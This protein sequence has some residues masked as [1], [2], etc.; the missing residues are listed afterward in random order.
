MNLKIA[1]KEED[2]K[3]ITDFFWKIWKEEFDLERFD[4]ID[5][6]KKWT[7]IFITEKWKI[8]SAIFFIKK[9]KI[10]KIWRFWTLKNFRWKGLWKKVFL[11]MEDF[12]KKKKVKKLQIFSEIKNISMYEKFWFKKIW[13]L[14]KVWN[15]KA[16]MM[17][18]EL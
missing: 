18:K 4:R 17:E 9:D 3:K 11:K 8:L 1:K 15:T 6:Y 7:T 16:V 5:E 10:S 14:Q 13:E 2:F 12:L